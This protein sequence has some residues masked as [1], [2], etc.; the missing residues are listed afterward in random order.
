MSNRQSVIAPVGFATFGE[1]LR[2]LRRR[3]RLTQRELGVAVGYSEAQICR[4]E[5]SRR[6]PDPTTVAALFLPALRLSDEPEL[7]ARLL[8][9]AAAARAGRRRGRPPGPDHPGP[10]HPGLDGPGPDH[11]DHLGSGHDS[12][13]A[14][15]GR[16]E[17]AHRPRPVGIRRLDMAAVPAAPAQLVDRPAALDRLRG[18]LAA[19]RLVVLSGLAG[20]GKT[21]LAGTLARQLA[22]SHLVCWF[23][24]SPGL[25]LSAEVLARRLIQLVTDAAP[26]PLRPE[27]APP[28]PEPGPAEPPR[29]LPAEPLVSGEW[30]R[31]A[32]AGQ[33]ALI[34]VDNAHLLRD[35]PRL[36]A[37]LVE[38]AQAGSVA[39]LLVSREELPLPGTAVVRLGGLD[40]AEGHALIR[41]L[42]GAVPAVLADRLLA[43]TGGSPMLL[44][45]ALGHLNAADPD[46]PLLVDRLE[47]Q[48]EVAS[49]LVETT[50]GRL[51]PGSQRLVALLSVFRRP[52]DLHD[53]T[54]L[55]L[56]GAFDRATDG[57]YDLLAAIA[58]LQ[59]R[60]IIDHPARAVLPPLL[61]D[62][63][64]ATLIADVGRRRRLHRVA[65]E[66]SERVADDAL[67]AA[68]HYTRAGDADRAADLLA[69]RVTV[70]VERGQAFAAGD[71]AGDLLRAVRTSA[72]PD[73]DVV[74][75]LLIARAD[76]LAHTDRAGEAEAA[77]R[78]AFVVPAPP[79]VRG[80]VGWRLADVLLERGGATEAVEL[81]QAAAAGL[82][83]S[84]AAVAGQL[85]AVECRAHLLLSDHD[86]A[87]GAGRHALD[88]AALIR[89][90]SPQVSAEVAARAHAVLGVVCRLRRET[91]AALAHLGSSVAA[92]RMAGQPRLAARATFNI[93]ALRFEQGEVDDAARIF[94]DLLPGM[95]ARGD[96]YGAGRVLHAMGVVRLNE[97]DP[98]GALG[99]LTEAAATKRRL[100]D[101]A[102]AGASER[103]TALALLALGRRAEA[104]WL[105]DRVPAGAA[106]T[107]ERWAHFLDTAGTVALVEGDLA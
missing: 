61:R 85:T 100:G 95:R 51:D 53:E 11:P 26:G 20:V 32:L 71:L 7:A 99:L 64:Y 33:P 81:C 57:P 75:R 19:E 94:A 44:R 41:R 34:C 88:L 55:E 50:L 35:D 8:E 89:P 91:A 3:V 10:D 13:P 83:D 47:A 106:G 17:A 87:V 4:L 67:E 46:A 73:P 63:G 79:T 5:Q 107:G 65:A 9:L 60:Q 96:S 21:T 22:D 93:G 15:A 31:A 104:Q 70:V 18:R 2:F 59:R 54:L 27:P 28:E 48:P 76:L 78:E 23:A 74:R 77:Y 68:W 24:P 52:V 38:L 97:G 39:V 92:A 30:V 72:G 98:A 16:A 29:R 66:W 103:G 43:R 40:E 45:L 102:G 1:L 84:D 37:L 82:P 105:V 14:V 86:T 25:P 49:Y 42:N 101:L 80:Q 6:L 58:E 36:L 62:H 12:G 69:A 56:C 90:F